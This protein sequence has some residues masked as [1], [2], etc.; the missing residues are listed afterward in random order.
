MQATIQK[1]Q[2]NKSAPHNT[3]D[4]IQYRFRPKYRHRHNTIE[5]QAK[6]QKTNVTQAQAKYRRKNISYRF[7]PQYRRLNNAHI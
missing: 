6:I 5:K 3:E 1:T 2:Y 7:R 4:K